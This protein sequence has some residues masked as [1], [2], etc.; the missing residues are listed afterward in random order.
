MP[1]NGAE[2]TIVPRRSAE[3]PTEQFSPPLAGN[4]SPL[5]RSQWASL[6]RPTRRQVHAHG[7][8]RRAMHNRGASPLKFWLSCAAITSVVLGLFAVLMVT[9]PQ[10]VFNPINVPQKSFKMDPNV[11]PT[12]LPKVHKKVDKGNLIIQ[13]NPDCWIGIPG[14]TCDTGTRTYR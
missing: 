13:Q 7:P 8:V 3:A 2:P 5:D 11:Q 9:K 6:V 10:A 14:A 4:C 1:T 12:G